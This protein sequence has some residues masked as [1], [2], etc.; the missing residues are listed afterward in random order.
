MKK[1]YSFLK[2]NLT[3]FLHLLQS[4]YTSLNPTNVLIKINHCQLVFSFFIFRTL[5]IFQTC[6]C[7]LSNIFIHMFFEATNEWSRLAKHMFTPYTSLIKVQ[8]KINVIQPCSSCLSCLT[9]CHNFCPKR[10]KPLLYMDYFI[11][12]YSTISNLI[13]ESIHFFSIFY[14]Q[15]HC[16]KKTSI[17]RIEIVD[18]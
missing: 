8:Q 13:F 5:T 11:T 10:T 18:L 3:T 9:I 2:S 17:P 16:N 14:F 4:H 15:G 1:N 6:K 7:S 12:I